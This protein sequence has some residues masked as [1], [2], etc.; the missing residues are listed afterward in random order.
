[1]RIVPFAFLL[2]SVLSATACQTTDP[3]N[4]EKPK[5]TREMS[6]DESYP[7][8]VAFGGDVLQ[9]VKEFAREKQQMPELHRL[10]EADLKQKHETMDPVYLLNVAHLYRASTMVLDPQL[11]R[12]LLLSRSEDSRRI[13]WRLAAVKPSA[14][15]GQM[16]ESILTEALGEER[17][18][19]LLS[20]EM[21]TALQENNL[22]S[23]FTFLTRGLLLQG[24][25]EYAAA[26]LVLDP[27]RAAGP[28]LDYLGK[29]DLDDLRQLNQQ[30]INI[31]TC[32]QIFRYLLDNP[33][34]INHPNVSQLFMFGISRNRGMADMANAVLEK[35]IPEHRLALARILSRMPAQV[36]LAFVENSQREMTANLRLLLTDFKESAQEKEVIEELRSGQSGQKDVVQ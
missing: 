31:Y 26:M 30:N 28:F 9:Q 17:E 20:P 1:M 6:L 11:L 7:L 33:L 4:P 8:A 3:N 35:H 19:S 22:K 10:A 34:P 25:P 29:A 12:T 32:T 24:N 5:I 21:A 36:Q 15:V 18:T 14:E 16:I 27:N 23:S 13:G 2:A